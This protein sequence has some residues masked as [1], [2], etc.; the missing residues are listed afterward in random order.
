MTRLPRAT[1]KEV[2]QA[3]L[4]GGFYLSHTRGSHHY[5]RKSG[6][7]GLV[8]VPVHGNRVVPKGTLR[9]ILRQGDLTAEQLSRL[10]RG[11]S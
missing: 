10:L 7:S 5:L 9:S 2:L 8:I 1:G 6:Q 4:R 3:L 11:E